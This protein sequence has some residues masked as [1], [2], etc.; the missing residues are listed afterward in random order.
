MYVA[1]AAPWGV[2]K[3][4]IVSAIL[5]EA[6][7]I[8]AGTPVRVEATGP[9]RKRIN[10]LRNQ[11]RG[12]LRGREF[13]AQGIKGSE[14]LSRFTLGIGV[15][16]T[17]REFR[18]EILDYPGG[19]LDPVDLARRG[20]AGKEQWREIKD[21]IQRSDVLVLPI[22]ASVLMEAVTAPQHGRVEA[23]LDLSEMEAL[24]GREWARQRAASGR[25]PGLLVLAPVKCETYFA[26]NGGTIDRSE[27]LYDRVMEVYRL[28]I[29]AAR[30]EAPETAVFY[31]PVDT[32][33]CV[34]LLRVD[35]PK[36]E[37]A[38][39]VPHF[40]VRGEPVL[41][42]KGAGDLFVK[43]VDRMLSGAADE[44]A[45]A[46][47]KANAEARS[48]R[49][50]AG[51]DRGLLGNFWSWI[52]GERRRLLR[53]ASRLEADALLEEAAFASLVETLQVVQSRPMGRRSASPGS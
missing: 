13:V 7:E 30:R 6:N 41:K 5:D 45:A 9:T 14:E 33:G 29:A 8:L 46:A 53:R 21:F 47:Q 18:I 51:Q 2:G 28:V 19:L 50:T 31:C 24:A 37:G 11:I 49:S 43:L 27:A 22:D 42:R 4:S 36:E 40:R 26:D 3:T 44:H 17:E 52:G 23:M 34:E 1:L 39:P 20:A 16:G 48:A 12:H 32:L 35:W 10:D 25:K 15:A 38:R